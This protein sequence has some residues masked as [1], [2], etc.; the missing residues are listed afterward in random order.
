MNKT[1]RR[2]KIFTK[3]EKIAEL[4]GVAKILD[5]LW[6]N[7]Y[8]SMGKLAVD[9]IQKEM[10]YYFGKNWTTNMYK[11]IDKNPE[12]I[13][14]LGECNNYKRMRKKPKLKGVENERR[15]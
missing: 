2:G 7:S 13:K 14:T 3:K 10:I 12:T 1:I 8:Y 5:M 4:T 11:L 9:R 6:D 15:N